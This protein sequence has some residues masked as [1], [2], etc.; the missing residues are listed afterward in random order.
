MIG[1]RMTSAV[2]TVLLA[3]LAAHTAV[4]ARQSQKTTA[5]SKV[6]VGTF[7]SRAVAMAY[8]ARTTFARDGYISLLVWGTSLGAADPP[9]KQQPISA[10]PR[11]LGTIG[12][13]VY[14]NYP[15]IY[16]HCA[17]WTELHHNRR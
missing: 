7:D 2:I 4:E 9:G 12:I 8:F 16:F 1:F 6:R 14:P 15:A 11:P 3:G 17:T 13:C 10:D 5:G